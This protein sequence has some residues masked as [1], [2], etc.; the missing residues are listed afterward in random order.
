MTEIDRNIRHGT[1]GSGKT[2]SAETAAEMSK[3]ALL[4]TSM[5]ELNRYDRL[6]VLYQGPTGGA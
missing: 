5:S 4:S 1:P 6:V 3:K 2:L